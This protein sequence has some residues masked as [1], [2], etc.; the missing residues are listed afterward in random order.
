MMCNAVNWQTT[1]CEKY[2]SKYLNL[3]IANTIDEIKENKESKTKILKKGHP[4]CICNHMV[5]RSC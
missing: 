4:S 1:D 2:C 3:N 5:I